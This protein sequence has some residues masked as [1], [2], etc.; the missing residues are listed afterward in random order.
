[1]VFMVFSI[2]SFS[3][4]TDLDMKTLGAKLST[5]KGTGTYKTYLEIKGFEETKLMKVYYKETGYKWDYKIVDSRNLS[6]TAMVSIKIDNV[7]TKKTRKAWYALL[8][9]TVDRSENGAESRDL[10]SKKYTTIYAEWIK[11]YELKTIGEYVAKAY[12]EKIYPSENAKYTKFW[13]E[14]DWYTEDD[15]KYNDIILDVSGST[16]HPIPVFVNAA[17]R[18]LYTLPSYTGMFTA[19]ETLVDGIGF[20]KVNGNI[21]VKRKSL[22]DKNLILTKD[23]V[24]SY[25][26]MTKA[27]KEDLLEQETSKNKV[28]AAKQE[29]LKAAKLE[30][31]R[32]TKAQEAQ[33]LKTEWVT[34]SKL[35]YVRVSSDYAEA[36]GFYKNTSI[37]S[38]D[39]L[40]AM[41]SFYP[42]FRD[43]KYSGTSKNFDGIAVKNIDGVLYFN[44]QNLKDNGIWRTETAVLEEKAKFL[45][46]WVKSSELKYVVFSKNGFYTGDKVEA[47]YLVYA[48]PSYTSSFLDK[49]NNGKGRTFDGVMMRNVDG[50]LYFNLDNLKEKKIVKS[51]VLSEIIGAAGSSLEDKTPSGTTGILGDIFKLK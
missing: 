18:E 2:F 36:F 5:V 16:L 22:E 46:S 14:S 6:Q 40:Y 49:T 12:R 24:K 10:A 19:K 8:E 48:T 30:E 20:K 42:T 4:S 51:A 50:N 7:L 43:I 44:M 33:I 11:G 21:L 29:Q 27:Q 17:G 34:E 47:K 37:N 31:E 32:V 35:P 23:K 1:M 9:S 3:A 45:K 41:P 26:N 38:D 28:W 13:I 25:N 15:L 39:M